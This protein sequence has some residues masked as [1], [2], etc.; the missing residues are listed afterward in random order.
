M[1]LRRWYTLTALVATAAAVVATVIA[2]NVWLPWL[3]IGEL[4]L[5]IALVWSY[6][7]CYG[8][9][10]AELPPLPEPPAPTHNYFTISTAGG[11]VNIQDASVT[12]THT[13]QA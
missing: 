11:A 4:L 3:A 12:F 8:K 2:S 9:V 1:L 6:V 5:I 10:R 13:E 7:D